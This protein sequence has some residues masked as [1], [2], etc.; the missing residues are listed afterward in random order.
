MI[1]VPARLSGMNK[2]AEVRAS[3]RAK[4]EARITSRSRAAPPPQGRRGGRGGGRGTRTAKRE[5]LRALAGALGP[6]ST[7]LV[8][9]AQL[10]RV[11]RL[12]SARRP[13]PRAP[14]QPRGRRW[15]GP[16]DGLTGGPRATG[17]R[18]PGRRGR[19][20]PR[21]A[22]PGPLSS[23][24]PGQARRRRG[25]RGRAFFFR[26]DTNHDSKILAGFGLRGPSAGPKIVKI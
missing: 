3:R 15:S 16:A 8:R 23:S 5:Q 22:G 19:G 4:C 18:R 21:P 12:A 10:A 9:V 1:A 11:A 7:H 17:S 26:R 24:W 20:A 6:W 25:Q 2:G 14:L 13:R